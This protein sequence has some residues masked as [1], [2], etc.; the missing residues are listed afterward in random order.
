MCWVVDEAGRSTRSA[1]R[2][3]GLRPRPSLAADSTAEAAPPPGDGGSGG[4]ERAAVRALVAPG[5]HV[6]LVLATALECGVLPRF[7]CETLRRAL[8]Q[9]AASGAEA[10]EKV[11]DPAA[12]AVALPWRTHGPARSTRFI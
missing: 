12:M 3:R 9:P 11:L 6:D 2:L 7:A 1:A 4:L 10:V 8:L 5:P